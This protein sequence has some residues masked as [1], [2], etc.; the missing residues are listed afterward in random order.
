METKLTAHNQLKGIVSLYTGVLFKILL[1]R[2][3][4]LR[5]VNIN[6]V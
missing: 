6:T 1:L 3:I 4:F 5:G 2:S